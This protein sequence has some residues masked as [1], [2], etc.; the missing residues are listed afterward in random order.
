MKVELTCPG[1]CAESWQLQ[2]W[3]V[4]WERGPRTRVKT[5]S[6]PAKPWGSHGLAGNLNLS[7]SSDSV[8][9]LSGPAAKP[10]ESGSTRVGGAKA[11]VHGGGGVQQ[12]SLMQ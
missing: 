6:T 2:V 3:G 7:L 8:S 4:D 10:L 12:L 5:P 9:D 1:L 11:R